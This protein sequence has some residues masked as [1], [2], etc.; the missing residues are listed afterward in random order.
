[1]HIRCNKESRSFSF[2]KRLKFKMSQQI[3][4]QCLD[5]EQCMCFKESYSIEVAG[6]WPTVH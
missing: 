4:E 3:L 6:L 5:M 1:M 2:R